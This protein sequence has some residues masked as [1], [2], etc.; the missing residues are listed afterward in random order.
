MYDLPWRNPDYFGPTEDSEKKRLKK[1]V[2]RSAWILVIMLLIANVLAFLI[3]FTMSLSAVFQ[4]GA[5][6]LPE[7]A[8]MAALAAALG[9]SPALFDFIVSYLPTLLAEALAIVMLRWWAGFRLKETSL[10][11]SKTDRPVKMTALSV[12][13][14]WGGA[15]VA[16]V[17]VG[18]LLQLLQMLGWSMSVPDIAVPSPAAD[19]L[20]FGLTAAYVCILG[21]ILEEIIFRGMILNGLK[22]YSEGAG[23]LISTIL[24]VMFHGN[25][26]Q[27]MTPLLVGLL[28]GFLTVRTG[29]LKPAILCHI[30]NN[31]AAV[32]MNFFPQAWQDAVF[33]VYALIGLGSLAYFLYRF[34]KERKELKRYGRLDNG[35]RALEVLLAPGFIVFFIVYLLLTAL[36]FII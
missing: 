19:P 26:V 23:I 8:D 25:L 5:Q 18:L 2:S 29:S 10:V 22:K 30:V 13:A 3:A 31:T 12:F 36:Y 28:L 35:E 16:S 14:C 21:P 7:S 27:T 11:S 20:G 24:F 33:G 15:A 4:G 6:A 9:M 1:D 32:A 17:V 34:G